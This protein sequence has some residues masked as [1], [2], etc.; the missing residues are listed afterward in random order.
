[1]MSGG[2]SIDGYLPEYMD[3]A[4]ACARQASS[5]GDVPVGAIIIKDGE[6]IARAHNQKEQTGDVTAH[7][8]VLVIKQ[9]VSVLG[10]WRLNECMMVSTLEPCP[11]CA[12][13]LLQARLGSLVYGALDHKWG[14]HQTKMDVVGSSQFNHQVAC[15]FLPD[16]R[17]SQILTDFFKGLRQA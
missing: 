13:T 1:M 10:D 17:C 7:A 8:E 15:H 11:M 4:L 12:G 2:T 5:Q 14:A 9:A 3:E 16:S 6:I